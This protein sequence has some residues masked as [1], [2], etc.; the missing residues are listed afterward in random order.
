MIYFSLLLL[1]L[2]L[3][4][5]KIKIDIYIYTCVIQVLD[6]L[7]EHRWFHQNIHIH[8][9]VSSIMVNICLLIVLGALEL[10]NQMKGDLRKDSMTFTFSHHLNILFIAIY[11]NSQRNN[12]WNQR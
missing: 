6:I 9:I 11:Q 1:L 5:K 3:K 2:L 10:W 7:S 12:I 8:G 4:N